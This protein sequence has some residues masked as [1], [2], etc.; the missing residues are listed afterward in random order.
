M[1]DI[2]FD[3]T[4][5]IVS[6]GSIL[7]GLICGVVGSYSMLQKQSLLGDCISHA[8]LPGVVI[9]FMITGN[10]NSEVLMTGAIVFGVIA[11]I[12]ITL[13]YKYSKI[14]FDSA[15]AL[16]LS[17]FFGLGVVL[18]TLVQK[19]SNAN[20]A[21]LDRFIYGQASLML[22]RDIYIIWIIGIVI[23]LII[24]L[25][26]KEFKLICF[27]LEYAKTIDLNT[28]MIQLILTCIIV[29][30]IVIGLQ[31]VGVILMSSMLIGPAV[32]A[33]MWVN[34]LS[35]LMIVAGIIGAF[36]GFIGTFISSSIQSI[37][38]GPV[39]VLCTSVM[40][41]LSIVIKGGIKR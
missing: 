38:T 26:Y 13:I 4:F 37:P 35:T 23:F 31:I 16:V 39:I 9:S 5:Q 34:K 27:D 12:L 6:I 40:I 33:R 20:Q 1:F 15:L 22:E 41:I 2:W 11:T 32:I 24:G 7:L 14:K 25:L 3:Y 8:A 17:V 19:S 10:K 28:K 18:L 30:S 29:V 36:S 21:G